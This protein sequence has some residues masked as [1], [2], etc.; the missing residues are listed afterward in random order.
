[1]LAR[2]KRRLDHRCAFG[3][4]GREVDHGDVGAGEGARD[5]VGRLGLRKEGVAPLDRAGQR[6]VGDHANVEARRA[7]GVEM[8]GGDA[9]CADEGDG[10][11][12]ILGHRRE[13]GQVGRR[14]RGGGGGGERVGLGHGRSASVRFVCA[15]STAVSTMRWP[16]RQ[17]SGD[18][19]PSTGRP[20][21]IRSTM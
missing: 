13:V 17:V 2:P 12:A 5:V 7:V 19:G 9:A 10:R 20:R 16:S 6:A 18:S 11:A 3:G 14:D 15:D 8:R 1:M 21:V 4:M